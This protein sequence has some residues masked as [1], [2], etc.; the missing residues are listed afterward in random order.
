M[1]TQTVQR[2]LLASILTPLTRIFLL[3]LNQD[4]AIH[5]TNNGTKMAV[6]WAIHPTRDCTLHSQS[7]L[8][9]P[10]ACQFELVRMLRG[11]TT[12]GHAMATALSDRQ[13]RSRTAKTRSCIKNTRCHHLAYSLP[14]A[15]SPTRG[16][17]NLF[18]PLLALPPHLCLCLLPPYQH[19]NPHSQFSTRIHLRKLT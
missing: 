8:A 1:P 5:I 13:V 15:V 11:M 3:I 14:K 9:T 19:P 7:A 17:R 12:P 18:I 6:P 4:M 16:H 10:D 2:I